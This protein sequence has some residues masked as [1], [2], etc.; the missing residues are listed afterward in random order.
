MFFGPDPANICELLYA[1]KFNETIHVHKVTH[2]CKSL[3]YWSLCL[4]ILKRGQ[5]PQAKAPLLQMFTKG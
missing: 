3:H 1:C 4:W 5:N 2:I